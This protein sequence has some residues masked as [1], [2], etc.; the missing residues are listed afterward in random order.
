MTIVIGEGNFI[1][2]VGYDFGMDSIVG[3]E[4]AGADVMGGRNDF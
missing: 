2:I 3:K 4:R 1:S